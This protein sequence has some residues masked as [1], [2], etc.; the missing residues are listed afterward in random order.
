M[1]KEVTRSKKNSDG[2]IVGLCGAG[3]S[4]TKSEAVRDIGIDS[5]AYYVAV[6]RRNVY[7]RV[8][9]RGGVPYLTTNPDGYRPNNLDDLPNC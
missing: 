7:V 5:W 9:N 2:D 6:N 1:S 3:W 4:R 8:G